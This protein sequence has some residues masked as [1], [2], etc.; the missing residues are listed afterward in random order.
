MSPR[1]LVLACA[2][3]TTSAWRFPG[4]ARP[5]EEDVIEHVIEPTGPREL[6]IETHDYEAHESTMVL[7]FEDTHACLLQS[8]KDYL[9]THGETFESKIMLKIGGH[10]VDS[11]AADYFRMMPDGVISKTL[12]HLM[13]RPPGRTSRHIERI[14]GSQKTLRLQDLLILA[15]DT[16]S[17][18]PDID[19]DIVLSTDF[20]EIHPWLVVWHGNEIPVLQYLHDHNYVC[21]KEGHEHWCVGGQRA[22]AAGLTEFCG[23]QHIY[24]GCQAFPADPAATPP[25]TDED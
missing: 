14:I 16:E 20:A 13:E 19:T 25:P 22:I 3:A 18:H 2:L 11:N 15:T 23:C 8:L 5:K 17:L 12:I 24:A 1:R 6:S 10:R 9:D 4:L 21:Y 7:P